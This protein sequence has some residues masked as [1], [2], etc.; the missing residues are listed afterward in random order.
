ML[1]E[2][3]MDIL[4]L[5]GSLALIVLTIVLAMVG[6]QLSRVLRD[7]SHITGRIDAISERLERYIF[8]PIEFIQDHLGEFKFVKKI[9]SHFLGEKKE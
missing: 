5:S 3:T 1:I 2:S 4:I 9:I 8:T 6:S 7:I